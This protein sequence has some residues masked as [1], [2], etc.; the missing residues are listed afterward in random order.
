MKDDFI[1]ENT[2][3]PEP[4]TVMDDTVSMGGVTHTTTRKTSTHASPRAATYLK[5]N[6]VAPQ[7]ERTRSQ[8]RRSHE[9]NVDEVD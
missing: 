8:Y 3:K 1:R 9:Y 5:E 6:Y 2:K 7:R 4:K